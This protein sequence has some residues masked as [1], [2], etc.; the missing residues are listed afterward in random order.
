MSKVPNSSQDQKDFD[1][2][3]IPSRVRGSLRLSQF[4]Q[5]GSNLDIGARDIPPP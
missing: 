2:P 4:Y 5:L 3:N 1:P